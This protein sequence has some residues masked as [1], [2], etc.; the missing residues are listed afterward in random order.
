MTRWT[1]VDDAVPHP[2]SGAFVAV[3][4]G[5]PGAGKTTAARAVAAGLD[6]GVHLHADDFWRAIRGGGV[7]PYLPEAHRQNEVVMDVV[8]EAA[9]GYA[10]GGYSVVVDGI[11]GPW[12]VEPFRQRA[13]TTGI[14]LHYVV[15]RPDVDTAVQRAVARGGDQLSDEGPIRALHQQ[16]GTLGAL[17]R[18][19]L[20]TS[21]LT[22]AQTT[23]RVITVLRQ[24]RHVLPAT[25]T[26]RN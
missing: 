21:R 3:L 14:P 24:G 18:H 26:S 19:V 5:P 10:R 4:T 9:F 20:D 22:P 15:L 11:V 17:E 23:A 1:V 16:F 25:D 12:F 2:D 8:A 7:P 13:A 6:R